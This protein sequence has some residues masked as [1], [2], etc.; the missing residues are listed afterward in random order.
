MERFGQSKDALDS[1]VPFCEPPSGQRDDSVGFYSIVGTP[2]HESTEKT[3]A[4]NGFDHQLDARV[5]CAG[6]TLYQKT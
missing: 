5:P 1:L 6:Y 3:L 2:I 4:L